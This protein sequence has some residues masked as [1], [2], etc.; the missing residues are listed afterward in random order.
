MRGLIVLVALLP[1]AACSAAD[2]RSAS[3][4]RSGNNEAIAPSVVG[5]AGS[6]VTMDPSGFGNST[7]AAPSV[8]QPPSG[9]MTC[10]EGFCQP[11]GADSDCGSFIVNTDVQMTMTPGN[12]LVIFD[13]SVSMSEPWPATNTTKLQAAQQ[14]LSMAFTPLKDV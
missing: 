12:V 3:D 14:A 7:V 2:Q 8:Q 4:R 5:A 13:Q 9:A 11:K 10:T 1:L 6:G